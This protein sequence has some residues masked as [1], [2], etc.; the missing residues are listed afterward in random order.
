MLKAF[1]SDGFGVFAAP[2]VLSDAICHS[3][4]VEAFGVA[5]GVVERI[6]AIFLPSEQD[7]PAMQAVFQAADR[8][9]ERR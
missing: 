7:D 8:V 4:R 9:L 3:H 2:T 5:D 1:G 6:Y